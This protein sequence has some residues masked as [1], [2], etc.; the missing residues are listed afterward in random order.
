M[1][2]GVPEW[3]KEKYTLVSKT[4]K[5]MLNFFQ[6]HNMK[7]WLEYKKKKYPEEDGDR[8]PYIMR[9]DEKDTTK[10]KRISKKK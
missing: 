5:Q 10:L 8:I 7:V 1:N 9:D 2:H 4:S 6:K 3:K